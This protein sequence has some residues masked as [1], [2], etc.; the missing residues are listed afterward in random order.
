MENKISF[1]LK[2]F[3][4]KKMT[5]DIVIMSSIIIKIKIANFI[6]ILENKS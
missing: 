5:K 2:T 3:I 4:M 6:K 1:D